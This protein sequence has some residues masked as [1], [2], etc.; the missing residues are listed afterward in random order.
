MNWK[1]KRFALI[2]LP[3]FF[4]GFCIF[5]IVKLE[6]NAAALTSRVEELHNALKQ[7]KD[8]LANLESFYREVNK[9]GISLDKNGAYLFKDNLQIF[10][11]N[12]E[13]SITD[14]KN[15]S[16]GINKKYN[17]VY[18]INDDMQI[19][20]G[21]IGHK[22]ATEKG[23]LAK[24]GTGSTDFAQLFLGRE[25]IHLTAGEKYEVRVGVTGT[26][27]A[28]AHFTK[29]GA[30]LELG[31][32]KDFYVDLSY[33][34]NRIELKKDDSKIVIGDGYATNKSGVTTAKTGVFIQEANTGTMAVGKDEGVSIKNIDDNGI[35]I[36]AAKDFNIE[37]LPKEDLMKLKKDKCEIQMGKTKYGD[38]LILQRMYSQVQIG[39]TK[40][41]EGISFGE[42]ST[43]T[44]SIIKGKGIAIRTEGV[45][46]EMKITGEDKLVITFEGDIDINAYG[47]LNLNSLNGNVNLVGKRI[48]FNE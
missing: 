36:S 7:N 6:L 2:S 29:E 22:G 44:L 13:I 18:M 9:S 14:D 31:P 30:K 26:Q 43:S 11:D 40:F 38:G 42:T 5:W 34:K 17:L 48:N 35:K 25:E 12:N 4:I 1:I 47:N 10:L 33:D 21:D 41:G 32:Q 15:R 27:K 23:M 20:F 45:G 24:I 16:I 46:N 8:N 37:M 39:E 28:S 3:V 19:K